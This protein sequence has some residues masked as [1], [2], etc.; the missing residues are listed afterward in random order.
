MADQCDSAF[1]RYLRPPEGVIRTRTEH[2][3]TDAMSVL[4]AAPR[5][6]IWELVTDV[7]AMGRWS[8]ENRR[9]YRLYRGP[10][11]RTGSWFVG[12]NRIG[13]VVWAT[14]CEVTVVAP[15]RHFEFRVHVVGPHWGYCL[16]PH[17]DGTL[18]TEYREWPHSSAF[19]RLLRVTGPLGLPRDNH[20]LHGIPATLHALKAHAESGSGF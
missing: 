18:V 15:P 12:L 10:G 13:P 20:A 9:G 17:P 11:P 19:H 3:R 14:P 6:R 5:E 2:A 1:G 16:D 7:T 4:I 8:T